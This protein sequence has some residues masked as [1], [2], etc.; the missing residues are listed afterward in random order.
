MHRKRAISY[1]WKNFLRTNMKMML[2]FKTLI[3]QEWIRTSK[4]ISSTRKAMRQLAKVVK[5]NFL[6]LWKLTKTCNNLGSLYSRFYWILV[7]KV[8]FMAFQ[9]DQYPDLSL[10]CLCWP[11]KPTAD[12]Q[13][14]NQRSS[15]FWRE[16]NGAGILP[17]YNSFVFLENLTGRTYFYLTW[18]RLLLVW[19]VFSWGCCWK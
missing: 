6:K 7:I 8:S 1:L 2:N 9:P 5:I 19:A 18:L 3:E 14:E 12:Y 13:N 11:W 10:L 4:K 16:W 15:I 17:K